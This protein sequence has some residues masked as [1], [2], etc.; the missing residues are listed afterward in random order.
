MSEFGT[1]EHNGAQVSNLLFFGR[2]SVYTADGAHIAHF[3]EDE[4]E[5]LA[6]LAPFIRT[7]LTANHQCLLISKPSRISSL[8]RVLRGVGV[9]VTTALGSGQL[10]VCNGFSHKYEMSSTFEEIICR[11]NRAG[12]KVIRIATDMTSALG[13]MA[14]FDDHLE[15]EVLYDR[16]VGPHANLIV[17]CQY[18]DSSSS[19]EAML[20]AL[21]IHPLFIIEGFVQENPFRL[22]RPQ[23]DS[24]GEDVGGPGLEVL[25]K[26]VWAVS[27]EAKWVGPATNGI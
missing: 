23:H 4:K 27:I 26:N 25:L 9:D 22:S 12:R 11:A 7:G 20:C 17:L 8:V 1:S 3:F 2:P 6:I 18:H 21:H 15:L 19:G 13:E 10:V 14:T 16:Y 24:Q 5:R